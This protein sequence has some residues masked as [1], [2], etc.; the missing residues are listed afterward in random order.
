MRLRPARPEPLRPA[1]GGGPDVVRDRS[2]RRVV[3][4]TR[5]GP[6][7]GVTVDSRSL[8][9][10]CPACQIPLNFHLTGRGD[11]TKKVEIPCWRQMYI[12]PTY[13]GGVTALSRSLYK[14]CPACQIPLIFHLTGHGNSTKKV[15]IPFWRQ[16]YIERTYMRGVTV[17]SRRGLSSALWNFHFFPGISTP[18][19]MDVIWNLAGWA[20]FVERP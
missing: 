12:E 3:R 11:S 13:M 20:G 9:K 5:V 19:K 14:S 1:D 10:S 7:G 16:L 18:R 2:G 17:D 8:Y 6:G 4:A 15:E